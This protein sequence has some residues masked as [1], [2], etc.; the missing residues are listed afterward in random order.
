MHLGEIPSTL[1]NSLKSLEV[2][3]VLIYLIKITDR[4]GNNSSKPATPQQKLIWSVLRA[5]A[6]QQEHIFFSLV[7]P[8]FTC[9]Q[10]LIARMEQNPREKGIVKCPTR[11]SS[12]GKAFS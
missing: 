7:A 11:S 10:V 6:K 1:P 2:L 8:L 4:V 9:S 3:E 5:I 12:K